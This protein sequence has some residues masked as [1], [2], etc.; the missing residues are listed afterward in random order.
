M[1][2]VRAVV[3]LKDLV[4]A[5]TRLAGLL[6]PSERRALAQ[7]MVEDVLSV[8]C[9]HPQVSQV[10]LISDDPAASLL[11]ARYAVDYWSEAALGCR[12]LN[13][14]VRCASERLLGQSP[15][16]LLVLHGDLP[17]LSAEDISAVIACQDKTR[18]LVIACDLQGTGTNLLAF[19]R[20]SVPRFS[21]GAGSCARHLADAHDR[22][23]A[24]ELL[25]R[26]GLAT[27][28]DEARDL[29]VVLTAL[30]AG[31]PGNTARLLAANGLAGRIRLAL[32]SL[33][34]G[35]PDANLD[36]DKAG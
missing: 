2:T 34:D 25:R 15:Q 6:S 35:R 14:V 11:A 3:P 9:A 32:A 27:D 4:Q 8:L 24:V 26:P 23:L 20:D 36:E 7:A 29:A 1:S 21:F 28:V 13:N 10:I 16:P 33:T 22:E 12:G 30:D 19:D 18:G 5:K 17:L 31:D